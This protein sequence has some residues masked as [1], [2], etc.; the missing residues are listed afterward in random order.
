M[1]ESINGINPQV[2]SF[3]FGEA[4]LNDEFGQGLGWGLL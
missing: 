1:E 3:P 2:L 4:R